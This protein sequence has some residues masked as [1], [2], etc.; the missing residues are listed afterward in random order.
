MF[1][2]H[3]SLLLLALA[4]SFDVRA[5]GVEDSV[6]ATYYDTRYGLSGVLGA[7]FDMHNAPIRG[8]PDVPS[9][10]P[11]YSTAS[12]LMPVVD[13]LAHMRLS[14]PLRVEVRIGF[15]YHSAL[16]SAEQTQVI[17]PN[18]VEES[19]LIGYELSTTRSFL[20]IAPVV[21]YDV[22]P[23][24]SVL[25]GFRLGLMM[26][27]S[28]SQREFITA[29]ADIV[30]EDGTRTRFAFDSAAI[31][32]VASTRF[33]AVFGVRYSIPISSD[34]RWR[35]EPELIANIGLTDLQSAQPNKPSRSQVSSTLVW[36][37]HASASTSG[38]AKET[39]TSIASPRWSRLAS[40]PASSNC[41]SSF[42]RALI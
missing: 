37:P 42:R 7:G 21:G 33:A 8:L 30:Y 10:C 19:A 25:G 20:S 9:C 3:I 26:S 32:G 15:D 27:S 4:M 28:F 2:L 41:R 11:Q 36:I 38:P 14:D 31:P 12:S 40:Q 5:A 18:G 6:G 13:L 16:L 24:L 23:Q 1:Y 22:A 29:P 39:K 17:A 34:Q 35:I